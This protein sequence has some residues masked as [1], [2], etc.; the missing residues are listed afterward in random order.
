MKN[1]FICKGGESIVNSK[2]FVTEISKTGFTVSR[3]RSRFSF[4]ESQFWDWDRDFFLEV[5]TTRLRQR[6]FSRVSTLRLRLRLYF[7]VS[8]SRLRLPLISKLRP[9]P[10]LFQDYCTPSSDLIWE[11]FEIEILENKLRL[12]SS[13]LAHCEPGSRTS[14]SYFYTNHEHLIKKWHLSKIFPILVLVTHTWWFDILMFIF[15]PML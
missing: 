7:K 6:L 8:R 12:F 2:H 11:K 13:L 15:G 10:R 1:S 14:Y 5:S 4:I 9:R 3:P